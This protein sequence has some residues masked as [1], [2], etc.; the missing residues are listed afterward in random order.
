MHHLKSPAVNIEIRTAGEK[1]GTYDTT[2]YPDKFAQ[3]NL[4]V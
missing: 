3:I 1:S 4:T 2:N